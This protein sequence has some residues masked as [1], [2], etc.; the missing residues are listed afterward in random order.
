MDVEESVKKGREQA[1]ATYKLS[2][3]YEHLMAVF[4]LPISGRAILVICLNSSCPS[5]GV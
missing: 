2:V 5:L 1:A 4:A 3:K